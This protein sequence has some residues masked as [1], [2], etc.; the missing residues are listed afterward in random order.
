MSK[1]D[2]PYS[3]GFIFFYSCGEIKR[4][5]D[6]TSLIFADRPKIDKDGGIFIMWGQNHCERP[7]L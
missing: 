2:S 5:L 4:E 3:P 6:I 1:K 7:K